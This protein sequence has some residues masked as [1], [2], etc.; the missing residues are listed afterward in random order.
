MKTY[1]ITT[2]WTLTYYRTTKVDAVSPS[3]AVA[4]ALR[5]VDRGLFP[6]EQ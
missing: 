6:Q 3:A 1:E 2:A 4:V 5:Q